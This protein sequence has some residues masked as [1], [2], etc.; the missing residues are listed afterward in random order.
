M[1]TPIIGG[2]IDQGKL[3]ALVFALAGLLLATGC[4]LGEPS[5]ASFASVVIPGRTQDEICKTTAAVFQEDGYQVGSLNPASMIFQKEGTRGQSLAYGGVV[6]THYGEVT[7]VRVRAQLVD[8]GAG[9]YRLQ[10]QASMVRDAGDSFFEDESRLANLR[11]GPYQALL[12]KVA[13]R[14]K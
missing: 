8:L 6:G 2:P 3:P 1:Y 11:S 9:S 12:D 4:R 7:M 10:C 13:K 5:S 14:L